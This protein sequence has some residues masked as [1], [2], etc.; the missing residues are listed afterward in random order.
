MKR[1]D[2]ALTFFA[3][4]IL[5]A[6][7]LIFFQALFLLSSFSKTEFAI[8]QVNLA[9]TQINLINYLRT[10][11]QDNSKIIDLVITSYYNDKYDKLEEETEKIFNKIYDKEKCPLWNVKGE[12][13]DE[14]FFEY[15][16]GFDARKYTLAPGRGNIFQLF[17]SKYI[18]TRTISIDLIFPDNKRAKITLREGC[19][20][21]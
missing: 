2:T 12:L 4:L 16:S 18:T 7:I 20:N 11:L 3:S 14:E 5:I 13:D 15:E 10:P 21:E 19:L 17:T 8:N 6:I 9:N 1:G